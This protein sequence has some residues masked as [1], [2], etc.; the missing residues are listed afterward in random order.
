MMKRMKKIVSIMLAMVMVLGLGITAFAAEN[1]KSIT[2]KSSPT[3]KVDDGRTFTA[4]K[5]LD[6]TATG[7]GEN[8]VYTVPS[9]MIPFYNNRYFKNTPN[10]DQTVDNYA[11]QVAEKIRA[12]EDLYAFAEAALGYANGTLDADGKELNPPVA[13]RVEGKAGAVSGSDYVISGLN[14][15]YYVIE[16]SATGNAASQV[17]LGT[18]I[19]NLEIT[20]K[21]DVPTIDKSIN[22]DKDT[23]PDT[24]SLVDQNNA[25]VGDKVP[26]TLT[27]KVPAMAGYKFYRFVISDTLS[28]GLTLNV[29]DEDGNDIDDLNKCFTVKIGTTTLSG[30]SKDDVKDYKGADA[31]Y[32]VNKTDNPDGTTSI[33]IVFVNFIALKPQQ[34]QDIVVEYSATLNKDAVIGTEGNPNTVKLEYSNDP[35]HEGEGDPENP[36]PYEFTTD[37]PHGTT[38]DKT[39]KTFVTALELVKVNDAGQTLAGAEFKIEGE[40]LN[41][42]FVS[43]MEFVVDNEHGTYWGYNG[44]YTTK[45]PQDY[46]DELD[47]LEALG[48]NERPTNYDASVQRLNDI[49]ARYTKDAQDNYVKYSKKVIGPTYVED[50]DGSYWKYEDTYTTKDPQD[51]QDELNKLE[52]L[53]ENER[54]KDYVASVQGLKEI[55]AKYTTNTEGGYQK[56]KITNEDGW[57]T[58]DTTHISETLTVDAN[59]ELVFRGLAAGTYKITEIKAPN[60]YNLL[61]VPISVKISVKYNPGKDGTPIAEWEARYANM[62]KN[63]D[64]SITNPKD[65]DYT[66]IISFDEGKDMLAALEVVNKTG[67]LL[68]STGGIGTTIFY[69]AGSILVLAAVVLLVTKKRMTKEK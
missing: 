52:A 20:V 50:A 57:K 51:Y 9:E 40:R 32:Y 27:S 36:N 47:K 39:V 21:A 13:A 58:V 23:D 43:G 25:A 37:D 64:G 45:N 48:E 12:E 65:E 19:D 18:T 53:A 63:P 33:E 17:M 5:I 6:A 56:Y 22:G 29:K 3:V 2:I 15:G 59:G 62:V 16:D 11:Y 34:G 24:G 35:S 38:E 26:Y 31:R 68:P 14:V 67:V 28:K 66:N 60:G 7:T 4:Y 1:D 61:P 8:V 41:E 30:I 54:P 46:K 49:L 69:V 42:I 10:A 44:T 55:L